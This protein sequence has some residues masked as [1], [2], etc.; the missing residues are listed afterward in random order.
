[1]STGAPGA[2]TPIGMLI[3]DST[4]RMFREAVFFEALKR[5]ATGDEAARL[6]REVLLDY[7]SMPR[8]MQES[9]GKMFLY[10]SFTYSMSMETMKAMA[11]PK[12]FRNVVATTNYHRK[13][14]EKLYGRQTEMLDNVYYEK[15][16]SFKADEG[17]AYAVYLRNPIIG[18]FKYIADIAEGGR[19]ASI[20]RSTLEN[21]SRDPQVMKAGIDGLLDIGYNPFLDLMKTLEME[22]KKPL[23]EKAVY[24]VSSIPVDGPMSP[25]SPALRKHFDL[26]YIPVDTRKPFR[27]EVGVDR[28]YTIDP[29]TG[30]RI[31]T[32]EP[33]D[34]ET[35]QDQI[36]S[37]EQK[38]EYQQ[39]QKLDKDGQPIFKDDG[40][41]LM[42][43]DL[44]KP[45]GRMVDDLTK[46]I[47]G[48]GGYQ[49]RFGS[50]RGYKNFIRYQQALQFAGYGRFINDMVGVAIAAGELP[51][52]TQF[53]YSEKGN[54]ILY[55]GLRQKIVR[56]PPEWERYDRQVRSYE[57]D[58]IEY[59]EGFE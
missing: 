27:A 42:V 23:P 21:A 33:V 13:Q 2:G 3:A 25:T 51:E 54:P 6:A 15:L 57:R 32:K 40:S 56:V 41:P 8:P 49:L 16:T 17:D 4:D 12:G 14:S 55:L 18:Q 30:E 31:P 1:M 29:A 50:D 5:G 19:Q 22:Y 9:I 11:S 53:G 20:L 39:M 44:S 45:T 26:E 47:Y 37:Y 34:I 36:T 35:Y 52:G 48:A 43:D 24:L 7:G 46:P 10:M 28:Y 38:R 58:L 59:M